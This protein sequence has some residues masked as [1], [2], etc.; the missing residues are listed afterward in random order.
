MKPGLACALALSACAPIVRPGT[1][2]VDTAGRHVAVEAFIDG[3]GPFHLLLDTGADWTLLSLDSV[4]R[5]GL[6][7]P[8]GSEGF[9]VGLGNRWTRAWTSHLQTVRVG[10]AEAHD[11]DVTVSSGSVSGLDGLLG[12]NFLS[13]F[14]LTLDYPKGL[15]IFADR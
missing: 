2:P 14:T 9:V 12:A 6:S 3:K 10:T 15:A 5:L 11:I 13:R 8:L 7:L 4:R 1:A